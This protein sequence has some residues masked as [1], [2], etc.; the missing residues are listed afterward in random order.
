[1]NTTGGNPEKDCGV[2]LLTAFVAKVAGVVDDN[3]VWDTVWDTDDCGM[4]AIAKCPAYHMYCV[5]SGN[6]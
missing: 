1:M 4:F 6:I 2:S 3:S 5:L